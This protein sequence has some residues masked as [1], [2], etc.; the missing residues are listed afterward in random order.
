MRG[1][2]L[3]GWWPAAV[4][5]QCI[6]LRVRPDE[7]WAACSNGRGAPQ[8]MDTPTRDMPRLFTAEFPAAEN[9]TWT[10]W[11]S[12]PGVGPD[13][14]GRCSLFEYKVSDF[15]GESGEVGERGP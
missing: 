4:I 2:D 6:E 15:R 5:R 11:V 3:M 10:V 7:A 14:E 8:A 9:T 13:E 12:W 1:V